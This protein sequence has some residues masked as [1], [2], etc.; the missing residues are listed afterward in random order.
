VSPLDIRALRNALIL[1]AAG[2][3][4]L[5]IVLSLGALALQFGLVAPRFGLSLTWDLAR[6]FAM[7]ALTNWPNMLVFTTLFWSLASA[8]FPLPLS[9][10]VMALLVAAT[11]LTVLPL[12]PAIL[13]RLAV[14]TAVSVIFHFVLRLFRH[15]RRS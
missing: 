7:L 14:V 12:T 15:V 2:G 3:V 4:L 13:T 1:S 9:F 5:G 11:A 10:A 6:Q 8:R